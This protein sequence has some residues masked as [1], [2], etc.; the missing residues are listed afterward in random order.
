MDFHRWILTQSENSGVIGDLARDIKYD[1]TWPKKPFNRFIGASYLYKTAHADENVIYAFFKAYDEWTKRYDNS[2]EREYIKVLL[3]EVE[4][5]YRPII[6]YTGEGLQLITDGIPFKRNK[7]QEAKDY[8]EYEIAYD[9]YT[10][11]IRYLNHKTY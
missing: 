9:L 8:E 1:D 5:S 7:K 10:L 3:K 11:F 4:T 2:I 6:T